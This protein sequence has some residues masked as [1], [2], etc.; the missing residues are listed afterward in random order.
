[1]FTVEPE[2]AAKVQHKQPKP[3]DE[4]FI[5]DAAEQLA[6]GR[7]IADNASFNALGEPRTADSLT[8]P[9]LPLGAVFAG[10][11]SRFVVV[12]WFH[13]LQRKKPGR[14]PAL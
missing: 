9:M 6:H 1:M 13:L 14:I 7:S 5:L 10:H 12:R 8:L 3:F 2:R 4:R 11:V